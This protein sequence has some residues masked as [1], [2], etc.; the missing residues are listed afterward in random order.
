[1]P[2]L[3]ELASV[4]AGFIII[5]Y[6]LGHPEWVWK[7][8]AYMRYHA[9]KEASKPWGCPSIFNKRACYEYSGTTNEVHMKNVQHRIKKS[10]LRA[11]S[12]E[13]RESTWASIRE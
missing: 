13:G 5:S 2:S 3:K 6:G 4:V 9:L 12:T 11:S 1:M 10:N 7:G 8:I